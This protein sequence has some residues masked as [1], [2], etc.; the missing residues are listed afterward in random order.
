MKYKEL[1]YR[2]KSYTNEKKIE[3]ILKEN[4]FKWLVDSEMI[5]AELEIKKD[6]LIW[7]N[8]DFNG[9]KWHYG[10]FKEG[11]FNRG[12]WKSGIF[13]P[14]EAYFKGKWLDGVKFW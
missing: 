11:S 13:E 9:G 2:G 8:G 1:K 4:G 6:T 5:K 10:I 12:T 3:D 7:L 14:G